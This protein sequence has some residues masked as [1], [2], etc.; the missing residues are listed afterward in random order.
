MNELIGQVSGNDILLILY[1]SSYQPVSWKT[2]L[3]EIYSWTVCYKYEGLIQL[4]VDQLGHMDLDIFMILI[5]M[6]PNCMLLYFF[7]VRVCEGQELLWAISREGRLSGHVS[8]GRHQ[9]WWSGRN[10]WSCEYTEQD[11]YNHF[12]QRFNSSW[13]TFVHID[14]F[15]YHECDKSRTSFSFAQE[16]R[17]IQLCLDVLNQPLDLV[18]LWLLLY[19]HTTK[20]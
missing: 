9:L 10:T 5:N 19:L 12:L 7:A 18:S 4:I 1:P 15:F 14:H 2:V 11:K 8:T 16:C 20:I 13:I 3:F 6:A 17:G